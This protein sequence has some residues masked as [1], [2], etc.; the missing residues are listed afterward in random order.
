M[1]G[2]QPLRIYQ[3]GQPHRPGMDIQGDHLIA[4]LEQ[5]L[6]HPTA[7]AALSAGH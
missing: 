2:F 4:Q 6:D 5:V 3:Q 7:D 1:D